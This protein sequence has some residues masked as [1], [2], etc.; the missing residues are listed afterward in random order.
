MLIMKHASPRTFL[1]HYHPLQLDTD[2]IRLRQNPQTRKPE[3]TQPANGSGFGSTFITRNGFRVSLGNPRGFAGYPCGLR[4]MGQATMMEM[5]LP[6]MDSIGYDDSLKGK[7]ES[8]GRWEIAIMEV[9]RHT[10]SRDSTRDHWTQQILVDTAQ[11]AWD[12]LE[13]RHLEHLSKTMPHRVEAIIESRGGWY[14][15]Y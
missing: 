2:M 5:Q 9:L 1:N 3:K 13:L 12:E 11:Q 6:M 8:R 15:A 14:T 7:G 4:M 10:G